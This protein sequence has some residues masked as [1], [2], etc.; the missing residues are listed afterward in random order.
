MQ[1]NIEMLLKYIRDNSKFLEYNEQIFNILEGNLLDKLCKTIDEQLSHRSAT[2][3]KSRAIPLNVLKKIIE[4][5]SKLYF[6]TPTRTTENPINQELIDYYSVN[7]GIN[8]HL[9]NCNENFNAYKN[10]SIEIIENEEERALNFRAIPSHQFLVWSDN[11]FNPMKVTGYVKFM[12][13]YQDKDGTKK[14]RLW[15]YTNEGFRAITSEG[16]LIPED[17]AINEGINPFGI[18]PF[19]YLTRSDYLLIPMEDTDTLRMATMIP[20]L[21]SETS[22]ASMFLANPIIYGVDLDIENLQL[23]PAQFW[24]F[25]SLD[26]ESKPTIGVIKPDLDMKQQVDY[27]K[28]LLSLW[29]ETRNIKAGAIGSIDAQGAASGIALAIREMDTTQDRMNQEKHFQKFENDLWRRVGIMHNKLAS[30]KRLEMNKQFVNPEDMKV[31]VDYADQAPLQDEATE[32]A[33]TVMLLNAGLISK[34]QALRRIHDNLDDNELEK[35]MLEIEGD[36]AII[37][38]GAQNANQMAEDQ[39]TNT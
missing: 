19:S 25:K 18:I 26:P 4:K 39:N 32:I 16:E 15:I 5:L 30:V 37:V 3:M 38:Q 23:S 31:V 1:D 34:S 35:L 12:G 17:M 9:G 28:D 33:N 24:N 21:L 2:I 14:N 6:Q 11:V 36:E 10:C 8:T 29:L 22:F 13:L 7:T 20:L 27:A